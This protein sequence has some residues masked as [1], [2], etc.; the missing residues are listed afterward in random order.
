MTLSIAWIR[1]SGVSQELVVASDSRLSSVGHVDICQKVF[2]LS[3]GDS[4]LAFC[5]D[6]ILAFPFLFQLQSAILDFQKSSDRSE[7]VTR[8]LGRV[9]TMLNF[10]LAAWQDTEPTDFQNATRTTRFLFGGWSW[11]FKRFF[12]YPIQ[13]SQTHQRFLHFSHSKQKKRLNLAD[14]EVCVCI[15]NY[16]AE[17]REELTKTMATRRLRTLNYE[18][19]D[20][21]CSMLRNPKFTDR[22]TSEEFYN[23]SDRRGTI[24]GAPQAIKIYEHANTRPIAIRWPLTNGKPSV[25]L[26][27]RPLFDWEM[28]FNPIYNPEDRDFFYPLATVQDRG[29]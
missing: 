15:G 3:R 6:T 16:T 23:K 2:P 19:L 7:D 28:T 13:F 10:Y 14:G 20:V 22:R 27:G 24:G 5:G 11:R 4:F 18:P 29:N 8:L 25:T 1:R 9:L 17:F 21:L 26:L 12:V